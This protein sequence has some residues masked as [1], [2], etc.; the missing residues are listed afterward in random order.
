MSIHI[1]LVPFTQNRNDVFTIYSGKSNLMKL[2]SPS[3]NVFVD[4]GDYKVGQFSNEPFVFSYQNS[5]IITYDN[6]LISLNR[7]IIAESNIEI[8]GSLDIDGDIFTP[9]SI[10]CSDLFTSNITLQNN[11][12]GRFLECSSN[13]VETFYVTNSDNGV[14]YLGGRLGIGLTPDNPHY[15]LMTQSNVFVDG[16]VVGKSLTLEYM[17]ISSNDARG[18]IFYDFSCNALTIDANKVIVNNFTLGNVTKFTLLECEGIANMTGIF[19]ANEAVISNKSAILNPFK[20]KQSLIGSAYANNIFGNPISVISQHRN[21]DEDPTILELS[22]CGNL[23]LGD[24]PTLENVDNVNIIK[25]YVVRGNIPNDR[26][27]HFKGY[28]HFSSNSL[29]KTAFTVNKSGNLSIGSFTPGD[30]LLEVVNNFTGEET[31][32][33][34]LYLNNSN[35]ENELP[36]LKC[37]NENLVKFQITSNATIC[38]TDTPIDMYKYHIESKNNYLENIDTVTI[39]SY[40]DDGI[41]DMCFSSL[42]NMNHA[43]ACNIE[44]SNF[45]TSSA[46][47]NDIRVMNGYIESLKV[48]SFSTIGLGDQTNLSIF[49]IGSDHLSFSGSN[50]VISKDID[51]FESPPDYVNINTDRLIIETTETSQTNVNGYTIFGNNNSIKLLCRNE[52][53]LKDSYVVQ[54]LQNNTG[55]FAFVSKIV[56]AN[57]ALPELYITPINN[58][59]DPYENPAF[60]MKSGKKVIINDLEANTLDIRQDLK[61]FTS[62]TLDV[63]NKYMTFNTND[64]GSLDTGR[65]ID[66]DAGVKGGPFNKQ[67]GWVNVNALGIY[68]LELKHYGVK[69]N[70]AGTLYIQVRGN[71]KLGNAAVSFLHMTS[72]VEIFTISRHKTASL[73]ILNITANDSGVKIQTDP[74]CQVCWTSIGSC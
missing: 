51:I 47:L 19:L 48:G 11:D 39:K 17:N 62:A 74:E 4:I 42:S 15:S 34:L 1:G 27:R 30:A 56:D 59:I 61:I 14:G 60:I 38:F 69:N 49:S 58:G 24:Y 53:A 54:E 21:M 25:D 16:E 31:P 40:N 7:N 55:G 65:G 52:N 68:I 50:I 8:K 66:T 29:E 45:S 44:T 23:I 22:S 41:I 32:K 73:G 35:N 43:Y 5:N 18:K 70:T 3:C 67:G 6:T 20:I 28:L 13:D 37:E 10:T 46:Y 36:F 33:T 57:G 64:F 71:S 9:V 12:T 63:G 72:V 26:E 2:Q